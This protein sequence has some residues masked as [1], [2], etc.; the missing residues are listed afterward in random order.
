MLRVGSGDA[1]SPRIGSGPRTP[2]PVE[3]AFLGFA[4]LERGPT[5]LEP[6]PAALRSA[7]PALNSSSCGQAMALHGQ[8][9]LVGLRALARE[10]VSGDRQ[11]VGLWRANMKDRSARSAG[12]P[13]RVTPLGQF[14]EPVDAVCIGHG[15]A[16]HNSIGRSPHQELFDG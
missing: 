2:P 13:Q 5:A 7:T 11:S 8:E 14:D 4:G 12:R 10:P 3:L 6:S 9:L 16:L 1:G 15:I